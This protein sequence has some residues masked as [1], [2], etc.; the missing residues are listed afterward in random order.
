MARPP[1]KVKARRIVVAL[2]GAA[3][4]TAA[5]E[6]AAALAARLRAELVIVFVEDVDLLHL[7]AL[8]FAR[9][10]GFPSAASRELDVAAMERL[11]RLRAEEARSLVAALAE[12]TPLTWSFEVTRGPL[13]E[14][15]L[16]AAAEA[17]LVVA[18]L[19]GSER[20]ALQLAAICEASATAN[21]LRARTMRELDALLRELRRLAG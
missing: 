20:A 14:A 16:A 19:A 10:I 18:A 17:E 15:L 1:A 4:G 9:E 7:A 13:T 8:P 12:R 2:D 6:A 5:L 21:L 11:L 3:P